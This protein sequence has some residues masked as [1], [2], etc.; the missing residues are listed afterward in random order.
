VEFLVDIQTHLPADLEPG[1]RADLLAAERERG[2]ALRAEG[3]IQRIWRVPGA[4]RNVGVWRAP[5]AT[6][7]HD[8]IASLPLFASMTVNVTPLALHPLERGAADA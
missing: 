1:R 4:T 8:A 5:D 3:V 2:T 7:L 6:V